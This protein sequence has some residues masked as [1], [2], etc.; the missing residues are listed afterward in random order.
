MLIDWLSL[1]LDRSRC[2]GWPG[3]ASL[4]NYG[5]RILRINPLTGDVRWAVS[6][7]DSIRSDSHQISIRSTGSSFYIQG[8]PA[9]VMG[10]GDTVFG[11]G[12][13]GRSIRVCAQSMLDYVA[14]KLSLFGIP[15]LDFW[16]CSRIDITCNYDLGSL[17]DVRIALRELRDI[18][19]GRYR[20][21]QVA[22]DT[23][24]W[25]H[26]SKRRS[27]KAY[28]KGPHL[29]YLMDQKTYSGCSYSDLDFR[30]ADRL[31][32]CELKLG[33]AYF[34]DLRKQRVN[35][36]DLDWQY[37]FDEHS[38]YFGRM[39]G[40][41]EVLDMSNVVARLMQL[42]DPN[43]RHEFMPESMAKAIFRTLCTVQANGWQATREMMPKSTFMRHQ[44]QLRKIG[45]G[46]GDISKGNVISLRRHVIMRPVFSW[47]DL[48][49]LG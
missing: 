19:G 47:S 33:S 18:E 14:R 28:A 36:F 49:S 3:W 5:D 22:G 29:R 25:S 2:E 27:G 17:P 7:W 10:S 44:Q 4:E 45:L 40:T 37:W 43:G 35:C 20:V 34:H 13:D 30:L 39:V 15:S 38:S 41:V 8:S 31:L 12:E 42:P 1:R 48:R 6:A 32:R 16:S 21:S 11:S 9:R 26:S 24:Y 46:D 23:V